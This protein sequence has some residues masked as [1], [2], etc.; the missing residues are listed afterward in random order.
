MAN[1]EI[2]DREWY[3]IDA[4]DKVLGRIAT[5]IADILRGKNKINFA[6]NA[7]NGDFV[8]VVNAD[9]FILTGKKVE[10]KRYYSHSGYLGNLKV[11]TVTEMIAS[12][13]GEI[14]KKAVSGMLPDN[15]LRS[16]FLSRLKTYSEAEHPHKNAKF[17]TLG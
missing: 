17:K 10:Q 2:K 5:Q 16:D 12:K 8:V 15:K 14:L 9:K 1:K 11:K 3:L 7:D 13:P 4:K 6:P